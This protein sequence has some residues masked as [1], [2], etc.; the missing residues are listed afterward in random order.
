MHLPANWSSPAAKLPRLLQPAGLLLLALATAF[1][2]H[3]WNFA[4]H[5]IRTTG[6]VTENVATFAPGGGVVYTPRIRFRTADG[7]ALQPI[8]GPA[9]DDPEFTP[10]TSVPV[11]YPPGEPQAAIIA[12]TGRAYNAAIWFGVWGVVVLDAALILKRFSRPRS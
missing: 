7:A 2:L 8:L 4:R 1:A 6:V 9:S 10:G 5:R 12:T 3:S 11:L